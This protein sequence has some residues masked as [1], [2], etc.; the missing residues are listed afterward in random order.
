ME[1]ERLGVKEVTE[2]DAGGIKKRVDMFEITGKG[3]GAVLAKKVIV[4][5]GGRAAPGF[6]SDGGGYALLGALGHKLAGN[7]FPSLTKF[8]AAGAAFPS[9]KGCKADVGVTLVV[10]SK[11]AGTAIG[12]ILFTEYGV[13]GPVIFDISR[14]ASLALCRGKNVGLVINYLP[15]MSAWEVGEQLKRQLAVMRGKP[16]EEFLSGFLGKPIG[17]EILKSLDLD[18]KAEAG[19]MAESDIKKLAGVLS[20]RRIK[21][22][23]Q[24]GWGEAQ[25]TAGGVLTRDFHPETMESRL[26]KGLYAAGEVLD[27]DGDCGGYNLHWAFASGVL[28]GIEATENV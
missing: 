4:A 9:I 12:E 6:G 23:G 1:C 5:T 19:N 14:G 7:V 15:G 16:G 24:C 26:E 20:A 8:K 3:K 13:S 2:F 11:T 25:V 28:A 18:K 22:T 17:R 27:I 10:N 21:I